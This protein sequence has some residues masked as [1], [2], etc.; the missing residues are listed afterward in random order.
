[1]EEAI[2]KRREVAILK[3]GI[4]IQSN[5]PETVWNAF[6]F[7]N[8]SLTANHSVKIFLLGKG[9]EVEQIK[10][11][12]FDVHSAVKTFLEKKGAMQ[13]CGTCLESRN[14]ESTICPA[15][16]MGNLLEIVEESE[17]VLVF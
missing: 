12:K 5:D 1:M 7:A 13:A 4:V 2:V 14:T 6:R 9:V 17:K 10:S 16:T 15:S 11:D 3:I 8:T